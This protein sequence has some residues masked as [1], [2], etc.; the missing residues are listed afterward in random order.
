MD[1]DL[2]IFALI[3]FLGF[4]GAWFENRRLVVI[5]GYMLFVSILFVALSI[6]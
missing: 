3:S 2:G 4:I 5:Y 6:N 1:D